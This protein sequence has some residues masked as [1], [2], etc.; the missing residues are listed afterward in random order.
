MADRD[1]TFIHCCA[2]L[3][4]STLTTHIQAGDVLVS[5]NGV[6]LLKGDGEASSRGEAFF[7][8]VTQTIKHAKSPKRVRFLRLV[9]F[10][11][12]CSDSAAKFEIQLSPAETSI[13][14]HHDQS[15]IPRY[16]VQKAQTVQRN[17]G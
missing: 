7:D 8:F 12:D 11:E 17:Q 3:T 2:C 10:D 16:R 4:A 5:I 13:L 9:R 15:A 1:R 6:S 14:L